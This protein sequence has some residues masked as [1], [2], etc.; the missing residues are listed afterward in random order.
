MTYKR[1]NNM[2]GMDKILNKRIASIFLNELETFRND[3]IA[4][5]NE[6]NSEAIKFNIHKIRPS[7]I[8]FELDFLLQKYESLAVKKAKEEKLNDQD[9]ELVEAI[10]DTNNKIDQIR[11][12]IQSI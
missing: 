5:P 6:K 1:L 12:F 11:E 9:E 8:I 4:L 10:K 3:L 7:M 2:T